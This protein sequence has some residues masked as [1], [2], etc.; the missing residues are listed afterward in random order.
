MFKTYFLS[1]NVT[2]ANKSTSAVACIDTNS[3][4]IVGSNGHNG[5]QLSAER[6]GHFNTTDEVI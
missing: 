5:V 4:A 1:S 6:L 2:D 3:T